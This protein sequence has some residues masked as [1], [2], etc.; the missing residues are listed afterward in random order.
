[1]LMIEKLDQIVA[2]QTEA[3]RNIK[4]D[5][6]TVWDNGSKGADGKTAT[7]D[8]LSGI[9]KS[10]PPLHDVAGMAGLELPEYLGKVKEKAAEVQEESAV[11][12]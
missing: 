2:L 5:K 7:S 11:A 3:I 9:V 1:M 4:I 12:E 8:F 10:L 6:V